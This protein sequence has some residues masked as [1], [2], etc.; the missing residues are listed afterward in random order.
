MEEEERRR[1]WWWIK[2]MK[3][4]P[5]PIAVLVSSTLAMLATDLFSLG[6]SAITIIIFAALLG[7]AVFAVKIKSQNLH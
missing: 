7:L 3:K 4:K 1:W 2:N 5:F 6:F